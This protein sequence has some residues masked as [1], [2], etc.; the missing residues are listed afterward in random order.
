MQTIKDKEQRI[1]WWRDAKIGLFI[2]YGI[3]SVYNRGEWIKLRE[4]ISDEEYENTAKK[5]FLY[6]KGMAEE[7][8]KLAKNAGMKYAVMTTQHHDGFSLWD[9]KI[10]PFNS[11]NCGAKTDIVKEFTDACRKHGIKTGLY[12][13]LWNWHHPDGMRCAQDES[14]RVRFVS[15]VKEQVRELMS[16]YGKIDI[17]W[18]DVPSPLNTAEKWE[19]EA[20]NQM[21]RELQPDILI[22][23]RSLLE[24]DFATPEDKVQPQKTDWEACLRFTD[25]AFGGL[26]QKYAVPYRT[27]ANGIVKLLSKCEN[28]CGNMIFNISPNAF[29]EIPEYEAEELAKFGQWT[30]KHASA[31]YGANTRGFVGANGICTATLR[32]NHVYLW[33]WIWHSDFMRIAGYTKP[34]KK[35]TCV[36]TGEELDFSY[37][38]GVITLKNLPKECPEKILNITVF[39]MDFGDTAPE[40]RLIPPNAVEFMGI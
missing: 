40:Y 19:S 1:S 28:G 24:E 29:G 21:V 32:N 12:F 25:I 17:L 34:P 37:E 39:D 33:N 4:G 3:Y 18:Y 10:N 6:K 30:E 8:V 5:G 22:N 38:N 11:V 35:V 20:R 36:T 31:V 14:A 2:H 16:N 15:Y 9:S 23:N 27:N 7:W 26:D 13:S